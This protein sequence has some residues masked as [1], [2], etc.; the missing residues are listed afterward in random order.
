[1]DE[2]QGGHQPLDHPE[3]HYAKSLQIIPDQEGVREELVRLYLANGEREKAAEQLQAML[4]L[5][6]NDFEHLAQLAQLQAE[7][8]PGRPRGAGS[9]A[10]PRARLTSQDRYAALQPSHGGVRCS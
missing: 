9:D 1:M 3:A 10:R 2:A 8:L 6:R 5:D 4:G 7:P